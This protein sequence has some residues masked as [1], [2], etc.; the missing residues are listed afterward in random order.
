MSLD[1]TDRDEALAFDRR[2]HERITQGLNPDLRDLHKVDWF[3][4]NPWRH[5]R[6]VEMIYGR[7]VDFILKYLPPSSRVLVQLD[8]RRLF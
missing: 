7:Y 8:Y 6:Y 3:Y 5:P 4:N 1:S 2:A